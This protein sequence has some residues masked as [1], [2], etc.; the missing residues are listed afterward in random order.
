MVVLPQIKHVVVMLENRSLD[1]ICGWLYKLGTTPQPSQFLPAS[2]TKEYDGLK[3]SYFN[4]ANP[5]Y[6]NG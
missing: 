2:S 4:P 5:Q 1:N 6:F 3:S